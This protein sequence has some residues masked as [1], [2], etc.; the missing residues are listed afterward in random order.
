MS[1]AAHQARDPLYQEGKPMLTS[2]ILAALALPTGGVELPDSTLTRAPVRVVATLP[3][4]ADLV[5]AIGGAEVEVTAIA[6]TNED[7][8]FVRPK[9]SFALALRRADMFV[10]T[11]L[12][13]ELWAPALLDR[14]GNASVS[15]GGPGYVTAYTGI[16]LLEVPASADRSGGDVHL[17]GNPHLTTDPL[18]A[19][20]VAANIATG[21]SRVAPD[22][23]AV[24]QAG[25]E[26][27]RGE[28]YRRMFGAELVEALGGETLEDLARSGALWDFLSANELG[29][30]PLSDLLG[31]WLK[32]AE[33]LR[34]EEIICYHKHWAYFEDRFGVIC[35]DYVEAKPGISPTPRHVAR[36]IDRMQTQ[37]IKV[38][39]A[40]AHF[41]RGKVT[42]VAERGGAEPVMLPLYS[43]GEGGA[44]AYYE[45]VDLWIA[46]VSGAMRGS[47]Q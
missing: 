32:A 22:R 10:T 25:L 28:I 18:R 11:G 29:G 40:A 1:L 4:Y 20:Q 37:G 31:G 17:F 23:A 33:N 2:L 24:F 8:H 19:L 13:L 21:L 30:R 46:R 45:L 7:S 6:S 43:S 44:P 47:A 5:R 34:G 15:E 36:L 27:F 14:A 38:L 12:D 35:A 9:P 16:A 42:S 39:I 41:D 3:V 26:T